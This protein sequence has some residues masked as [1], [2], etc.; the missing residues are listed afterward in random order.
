MNTSTELG[1]V[2]YALV[3]TG[4]TDG[5]WHYDFT[6][7][8]EGQKYLKLLVY[9]REGEP[10]E[11]EQ[12]RLKPG[13]EARLEIRVGPSEAWSAREEGLP[14]ALA[15]VARTMRKLAGLGIP[16]QVMVGVAGAVLVIVAL[17]SLISIRKVLV[18]E[19]AIVFRG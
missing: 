16:W 12:L 1:R 11:M 6:K 10:R 4:N 14:A 5:D 9:A 18:L 7:L 13:S 3:P 8:T 19:P 17:S 15:E 2:E